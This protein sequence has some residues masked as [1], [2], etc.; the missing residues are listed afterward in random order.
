MRLFHFTD[1]RN[2]PSIRR[3]GL[4][5]WSRLLAKGLE[6][7]PASSPDSRTYD[8]RSGLEDYVRLCI[9]PSHPMADRAVYEGRIRDYV[10]LE[11]D[12]AVT[13]WASTLFANDNAVAKRTVINGDPRTALESKTG[14]AEVLIHGRLDQRWI[15]F[16]AV[17]SQ[18]SPT[19]RQRDL[20]APF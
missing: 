2:L 3:H 11:V 18:T 9:R 5:S 17:P 8:A 14:Q 13:R 4:L 19:I 12:E 7:W 1:S 6:H 16:P 15:T 20:D 10:W